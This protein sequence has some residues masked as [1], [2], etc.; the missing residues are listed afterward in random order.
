VTQVRTLISREHR[1]RNCEDGGLKDRIRRD[2]TIENV[3]GSASFPT[4]QRLVPNPPGWDDGKARRMEDTFQN[5]NRDGSEAKGRF[6]NKRHTFKVNT[7]GVTTLRKHSG[8]QVSQVGTKNSTHSW[9]TV[10][11]CWSIK[12]PSRNGLAKFRTKPFHKVTPS[13]KEN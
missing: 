2:G 6:S 12:Y 10:A 3:V 11:N 4:P 1:I 5:E 8:V 9:A 13:Q 7:G